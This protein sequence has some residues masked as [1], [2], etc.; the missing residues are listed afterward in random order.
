MA[1]KTRTKKRAAPRASKRARFQGLALHVTE[2]DGRATFEAL[3]AE[4]PATAAFGLAAS[5]PQNLDPE[6]AAKRIL[7][8]ALASSAVPALTA[9][10]VSGAES[11]VQEPR[12]RDRAA[13]RHQHRQ[14]PPAA[15]RHPDLRLADQRRARRRQRDRLAQFQSR[16]AGRPRRPSPRS[17]RT[18][19]LKRVGIRGRLRTRASRRHAGAELLS[20]R[21]GQVAPRLR[22]REHPQPQEPTRSTA[23]Q[24]GAA[25][26]LSTTSS[27]RSAV[28]W[29]PS[30]RAR[31]RWRAPTIPASTSSAPRGPSRSSI[32]GS[33]KTMRDTA[34]NIETFD[35]RF[36]DP[37]S[38]GKKPARN[39]RVSAPWSKAAV[40]AHVNAAV[41]ASFLRDVLKRNN[42]DNNGGKLDLD[43]QL[44]M[45]KT[46]REPARQQELAE[47]VLGP[48][49]QADDLRSG[50]RYNDATALARRIARRGRARAVS[51]RD[52]RDRRSLDLSGRARRA[53]TNPI[54]TFS[55]SSFP[56]SPSRTS[57]SGTG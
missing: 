47:R 17:R 25:A 40:S 21:Q 54:R 11:D 39:A 1:K 42:V 37:G 4:R 28:R 6:S 41:V 15:A 29:S 24:H 52:R 8:H 3:R 27:M 31:P 12:R 34:L 22:R 45:V 9:P 18:T 35:F 38:A 33:K 55:A 46:R 53:R 32:A 10:K 23:A 7:E 20:R 30:C 44:R 43:R 56:I 48:R 2:A 5:R 49:P 13:D 16:G 57:A 19:A 26:G 51:R 36:R 50:R 14:V